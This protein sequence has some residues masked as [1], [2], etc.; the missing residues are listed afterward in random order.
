MSYMEYMNMEKQIW[1]IIHDGEIRDDIYTIE[2]AA[3]FMAGDD[4]RVMPYTIKI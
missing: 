3:R 2:E 4:D 1:L